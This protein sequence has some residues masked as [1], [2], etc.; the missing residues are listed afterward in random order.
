MSDF[1][2]RAEKC[3]THHYAC[4]C[5]EY[6][7]RTAIKNLEA[8]RSIAAEALEAIAEYSGVHKEEMRYIARKALK[9]IE[10]LDE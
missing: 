4:D 5:R 2:T 10:F 6:I 1:K 8:R 3:V 7:Y 9:K